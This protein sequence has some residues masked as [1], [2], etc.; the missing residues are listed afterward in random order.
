MQ[1]AKNITEEELQDLMEKETMLTPDMALEYGFIDEISGRAEVQEEPQQA[2]KDIK[3]LKEKMQAANFKETLEEFEELV[4]ERRT[5]TES[6]PQ[7]IL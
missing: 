1:R 7:W 5:T 4:E 3:E 2:A 6:I